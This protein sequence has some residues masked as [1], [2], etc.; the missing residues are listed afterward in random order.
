MDRAGGEPRDQ[1][2][3]A[4]GRDRAGARKH[5]PGRH[6]EGR[7]GRDQVT[8]SLA[9]G[10]RRC[11][12]EVAAVIERAGDGHAVAGRIQQ[13]NVQASERCVLRTQRPIVIAVRERAAGDAGIGGRAVQEQQPG[14]RLPGGQAHPHPV[15]VHDDG[16]AGGVRKDSRA[17][18]LRQI[19][20]NEQE[21]ARTLD[22][23]V[24]I[25]AAPSGSRP[26][27]VAGRGVE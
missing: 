22:G 19:V 16:A 18:A 1:D 14:R 5:A 13:V 20:L 3:V 15:Q 2:R 8:A 21:L 17:D 10:T 23:E 11:I 27:Q 25:A 24:E 6:P 26:Q 7:R 4:A 9:G 12:E